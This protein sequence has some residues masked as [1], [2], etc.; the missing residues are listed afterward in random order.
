MKLQEYLA[1]SFHGAISLLKGLHITA[2]YFFHPSRIVTEQYPNNKKT[3]K[4]AERFRGQVIMP[5]D[6]SGEHKCTA[7]TMCE[8][9]CPNG[10]ISILPTK[11]VAGKKVLGQFIY[12]FDTCTLCSLCVEACPFDAIRMGQNFE[13]SAYSREAF[14]LILNK[15]EGRG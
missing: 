5:H 3:L 6:E 12:R 4:M 1:K 9:A 14:E 13:N 2:G 15:K 8:K 11:N 10:S 7:C